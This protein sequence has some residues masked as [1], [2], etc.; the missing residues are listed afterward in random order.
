MNIKKGLTY[1]AFGF[2]FILVNFNL[3][4][5]GK[6][7]NVMPNFIGWILMYLAHDKLSDYTSDKG[8]LK[9]LALIMA[10]LSGALWIAPVV[11]PDV[12]ITILNTISNILSAIYM[13]VLFGC[14]ENVARDYFPAK[15]DTIK[16][17]RY[18]NVG[19]TIVMT[20]IGL[21]YDYFS[22]SIETL[23]IIVLIMSLIAL[24]S[25]IFTCIVLF[26]LAKSVNE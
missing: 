24:V 5:N 8:Y 18:I 15:K 16:Y 10:I 21:L 6:T 20:L 23:A 22:I 14:L 12:K 1:I 11:L 9:P 7:L 3:T 19:V 26:Q 2:L 13:F 25:A 4:L 17:L